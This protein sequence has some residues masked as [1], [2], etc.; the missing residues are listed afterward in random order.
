MKLQACQF[1]A[2]WQTNHLELLTL[3]LPLR[4]SKAP[5]SKAYSW[6]AQLKFTSKKF[7]NSAQDSL[8]LPQN[9]FI[10]PFLQDRRPASFC[11]SLV[12]P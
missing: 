3:G 12:S 11:F 9:D 8:C 7:P 10:L 4:N 6:K 2:L 5:A 1:L